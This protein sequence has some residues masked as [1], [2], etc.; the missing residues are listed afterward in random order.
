M[1]K[2]YLREAYHHEWLLTNGRGGYAMSLGDLINERRYNGL[3][4]AGLDGLKRFHLLAGLEEEVEWQGQRFFLDSSHYPDCVHPHGFNHIIKSWLRPYPTVLY[5]TQ[6]AREDFLILKEIFLVQKANAVVVRYSN[7]GQESL[8]LTLR[9]KFTF[10]DLHQLNQP[11]SWDGLAVESSVDELSFSLKKPGAPAAAWGW[12]ESGLVIDHPIIFR[13][14]F[15]PYDAIR[16]Y[17]AV[18]DLFAPVELRFNLGPGQANRLVVADTELVEPFEAAGQA[19]RHYAALPLPA[20]HPA[21]IDQQPGWLGSIRYDQEVFNHAEYLEILAFSARDFL[22]D[23]DIIAGYP[24]FGPLSR[25]TLVCLGGLRHLSG[26]QRLGRRILKKY[27]RSIKDGLLPLSLAG[28][29]SQEYDSVDAP[30][31]YV[32]RCWEYGPKDKELLRRSA[33]IV[34]NYLFNNRLPFF[35]GDDGL[36]SL[37]PGQ[38]ALT[39]MDAV[40]HDRP[41][42]P[43]SGKPVEINALWYNAVCCLEAMALAQGWSREKSIASG[44]YSLPLGRLSEL[45]GQIRQGL[46]KFIGPDYLADRLTDEGPIFELRPNA[47]IALSLPFDWL[48]KAQ[49]ERVFERAKAELLTPKGLRTLNPSHSAFKR[50]YVGNQLQR[51]LAYHQ[52][53]IWAWLLAPFARLAHKLHSGRK[54]WRELHQ[55]LS[56]C[57]WRF[58]RAYLKNHIAS[59]AEIWDGL[60]PQLPRGCPAQAW[61][62]MALVE[63]EHLLRDLGEPR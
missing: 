32:I 1:E 36:V 26:G 37:R 38:K 42:T 56:G 7:L 28:D 17:E 52:G 34:L 63:V 40:A 60:D 49:M 14:V 61:S 43:R 27:G 4:I 58:R 29:G 6:P 9:P 35:V 46:Q 54:D 47:V 59:V 51:D 3:L 31:W 25:Q 23:D 20:D 55:E 2:T 8:N 48:D 10:R 33:Q 39:W 50:K 44:G 11:G 5:S 24:W 21:K 53:T 57:I 62:V 15:Y 19:E 45:V 18:E 16:G 12:I 30:L 13:D 22:L 41:V